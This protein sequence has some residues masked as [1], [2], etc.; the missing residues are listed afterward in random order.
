MK[1]LERFAYVPF[2]DFQE[3][4]AYGYLTINSIIREKDIKIN[5]D[6]DAKDFI[7]YIVEG[8][9]RM[10]QLIEDLARNPSGK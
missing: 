10:R 1:N 2:H 6:D 3:P 9:Q 4:I 7:E 5:L 8:A